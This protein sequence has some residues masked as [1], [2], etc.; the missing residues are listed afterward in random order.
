LATDRTDLDPHTDILDIRSLVIASMMPNNAT[1]R[2]ALV[3]TPLAGT[4]SGLRRLQLASGAPSA[5]RR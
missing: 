3:G 2:S 1:Q 5:R 4:A